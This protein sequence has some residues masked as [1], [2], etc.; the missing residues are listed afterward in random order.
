MKTG[1]LVKMVA[2]VNLL[3]IRMKEHGSESTH[4]ILLLIKIFRKHFKILHK[5]ADTADKFIVLF[6]LLFFCTCFLHTLHITAV[7]T[8]IIVTG[9]V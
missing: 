8:I 7:I 9:C 3:L 5:F 1:G 2:P 4:I 6:S